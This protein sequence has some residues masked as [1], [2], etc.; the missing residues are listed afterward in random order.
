MILPRPYRA[1]KLLEKGVAEAKEGRWEKALSYFQ[2][3]GKLVDDPRV[4]NDIGIAYV[5]LGDLEKGFYYLQ[6]AVE[7]DPNN[8]YYMLNLA[9]AYDAGKRYGLALELYDKILRIK[10][11]WEVALIDKAYTLSNLKKVREAIDIYEGLLRKNPH[12]VIVLSSL[13][14]LYARLGKFDKALEF[15]RKVIAERNYPEIYLAMG[16]I[17]EFKEEYD[18]AMEYYSEAIRENP[19]FSLA[20]FLYGDLKITLGDIK[21]G[22]SYLEKSIEVSK[23]RYFSPEYLGGNYFILAGVK[24]SLGF[25]REA[26][27]Y[28]RKAFAMYP[29]LKE[30]PRPIDVDAMLG[31]AIFLKNSQKLDMAEKK[32]KEIL[33]VNKKDPL[34]LSLLGDVYYLKGEMGSIKKRQEFYKKAIESYQKSLDIDPDQSDVYVRLGNIYFSQGN[35]EV[36][37]YRQGKY[38][39][40]FLNFKKAI[41]LEPSNPAAHL[42]LALLYAAQGEY[43]SSDTGATSSDD[44]YSRAITEMTIAISNGMG[45]FYTYYFLGFLYFKRNRNPEDLKMAEYFVKKSLDLAPSWNSSKYLL[46]MIK[47]KKGEKQ[48]ADEILASVK[49]SSRKDENILT[50][51]IMLSK[52]GG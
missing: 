24:E 3:A 10:P 40:A 27:N 15:Y 35:L 29:A 21:E 44:Y 19:Y 30:R 6:K 1:E 11:D 47:L 12:D 26:E 37:Y 43:A 5:N 34:A 42:S 41:K 17:Y 46:A 51:L 48:E 32:V 16:A 22:L 36:V 7:K 18:K 49:P 13:G 9:V 14:G 31:L 4:Y 8:V 38:H 52:R 28:Y 33:A 45:N 20:Y 2:Q 50:Y 23:D 39:Q 25:D